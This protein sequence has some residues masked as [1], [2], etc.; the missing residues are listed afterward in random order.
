MPNIRIGFYLTLWFLLALGFDLGS[1]E[2]HYILYSQHLDLSYFDHPPLVGWIHYFFQ[3][4][5]GFNSLSA[6]VPS[7]LLWVWAYL[8]LQKSDLK[9]KGNLILLFQTSLV[10][11][12][13]TLFML[14]DT[15]LIPLSIGIY[16][17]TKSLITKPNLKTWLALG[18]YLGLAGLSKYSAVL[19]VPPV[20]YALIVKFR[21]QILRDQG[22]YL[23]TLVALSLISPVLV[24][25]IQNDFISFRYQFQHV[26]GQ[27]SGLENFLRSALMQWIGY[28]LLLVPTLMLLTAKKL[29]LVYRMSLKKWFTHDTLAFLLAGTWT[30]FFIYSSFSKVTLPHWTLIGW[31]FWFLVFAQDIPKWVQK[32]Q[33][34]TNVVI[35]ALL[36]AI[37]WIPI[38]LNFK[39]N[40]KEVRGWTELLESVSHNMASDDVLYISNWSYGS[41][42]NLYANSK[43]K[44]KIQ[45]ADSRHD[46]FDLWES[47]HNLIKDKPGKLLVFKGDSFDF[48]NSK[49][50][51]T[52][53]LKDQ[54]VQDS[55]YQ[56]WKHEFD[57]YSCFP[58]PL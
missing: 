38:N 56:K 17:L 21:F 55:H 12:A 19:L 30:A 15:P 26:V 54:Q 48:D 7:L 5:F 25:N 39:I 22:F 3:T 49:L 44:N 6:R 1:D 37:L 50:S 35:A 36:I 57:L 31:L 18:L 20:A 4:L 40:L 10:P 34:F 29:T 11:L 58:K 53:F 41:R 51:C 8:E 32:I 9:I 2:S 27:A 33:Y 47:R 16:R 23:C 14:P 42:A 52:I 24:W 13:L 46:Q 28:G 43:L 45:I